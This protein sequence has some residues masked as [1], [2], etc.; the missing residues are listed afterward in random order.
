M[1]TFSIH[2]DTS[3]GPVHLTVSNLDRSIEFYTNML[4]FKAL[5]TENNTA[6]LT[7]D[8]A[9]PL[10]V[11]TGQP[12]ARPKPPHTTGLYHF[13]ILLPSRVDLARSLYRL[14][15]RRYPIGA[16]DHLVS[17]ALYLSDP[18]D[19]GIEIYRDRPRS[20][21]PRLNGQLQ[22]ATNP[23]DFEG[24]LGELQHH[25]RPWAGLPAQTRL[26]HIHLHVANLDQAE[27]FYRDVLGFDLVLR[28]GMGATFL[29]AGGY[30]HHIGANTW[31][32]VGVPPPPPDAVGLRFFTINLP[33][34]AE[35]ERLAGHLKATGVTFERDSA[36]IILHDPSQNEV[37]LTA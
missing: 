5:P 19:N 31:A 28:Y 36:A 37:R 17:E 2:P 9:T 21:W 12:Q 18:D 1:H 7:A 14:V 23:L 16:S 26:G 33:D 30:H 4:G 35:L 6:T 34:K 13:A 15:E 25:N 22:M 24:V 32:G 3:L 10:L 11:L 8:G 27:A 29:S 20:D